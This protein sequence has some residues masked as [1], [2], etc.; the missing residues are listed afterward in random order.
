MMRIQTRRHLTGIRYAIT[1]ALESGDAPPAVGDTFVVGDMATV[2][3]VA[4]KDESRQQGRKHGA[5]ERA[6][7]VETLEIIGRLPN[8]S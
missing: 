2:R 4:L 3:V 8:L 5:R 1:V 7:T 6:V